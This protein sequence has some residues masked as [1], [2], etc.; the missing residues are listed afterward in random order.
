MKT[1]TKKALAANRRNAAR[2]TGPRTPE[3]KA[4][5]AGNRITH[6]MVARGVLPLEDPADL[7]GLRET[8]RGELTPVGT[9]ET[10]LVD[11]A[12]EILFR[13]R[14]AGRAETGLFSKETLGL[15][16]GHESMDNGP[17]G[18]LFADIETPLKREIDLAEREPLPLLGAAFSRATAAPADPLGKLARY[19]AHLERCLYR[20]LHELERL[21]RRRQG[22]QTPAPVAVDITVDQ[23]AANND[24]FPIDF[25]KNG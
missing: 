4:T 15:M 1:M 13:L 14:R 8:L 11:R 20:A 5:V 9:L 16:G 17:V 22:E 7:A 12:A 24:G 6:G 10:E 19:E 18:S 21:Q 25:E 2:S 23:V 3:G